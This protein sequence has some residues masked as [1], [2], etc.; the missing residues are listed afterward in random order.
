MASGTKP[1]LAGE[2]QYTG[3]ELV[4]YGGYVAITAAGAISSQRNKPASIS[5]TAAGKYTCT[6]PASYSYLHGFTLTPKSAT[7]T[8]VLFGV[9]V[10]TANLASA[11]TFTFEIRTEAGTCT[12][13]TDGDGFF[14]TATVSD[15]TLN[16][17][18]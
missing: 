9:V 17:T 1:L 11:G 4:E 16:G 14:W 13:P 5:R 18:V 3:F 6:L 7:A 10:S 12:D 15:S 8:A 2:K